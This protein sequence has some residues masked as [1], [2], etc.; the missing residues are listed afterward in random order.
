LAPL[1]IGGV[2]RFWGVPEGSAAIAVAA[3][4]A[5]AAAARLD[6]TKTE[7]GIG[8]VLYGHVVLA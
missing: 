3:T 8:L 2:A 6:F 7:I 4:H 5:T 1:L